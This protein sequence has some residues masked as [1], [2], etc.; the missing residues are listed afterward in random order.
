MRHITIGFT[1]LTQYAFSW[2]DKVNIWYKIVN[3]L[4]MYGLIPQ[5]V[6]SLDNIT[7]LTI[8][9]FVWLDYEICKF[10]VIGDKAHLT[11]S[12]S[13]ESV[14]CSRQERTKGSNTHDGTRKP[15]I[16]I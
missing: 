15:L 16:G 12:S 2:R 7:Q 8:R 13:E 6:V 14:I 9:L 1:S 10:G 3:N 11:I 4:Q 5:N